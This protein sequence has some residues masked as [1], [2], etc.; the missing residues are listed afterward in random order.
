[1]VCWGFFVCVFK[2][3]V[4]YGTLATKLIQLCQESI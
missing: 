1:M 3:N 4:V 2:L